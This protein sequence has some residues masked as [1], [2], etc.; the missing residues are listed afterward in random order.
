MFAIA[1]TASLVLAAGPTQLI[2][3]VS[4]PGVVVKVDGK[5]AGTSGEKPITLKVAAGKHIVR[6][7]HKGDSHEEEVPVKAGEKKT[8][9]L[10]LE[11]GRTA[12]AEPSSPSEP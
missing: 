9:V 4:P 3:D 6:L 10:K 5:K 12:P 7:E 2:I 8:F 1:L 11:D